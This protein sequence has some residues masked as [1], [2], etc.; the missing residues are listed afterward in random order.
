MGVRLDV[1]IDENSP[2]PISGVPFGA[3]LESGPG[4]RAKG[5]QRA[6]P[7]RGGPPVGVVHHPVIPGAG[8]VPHV[9]HPGQY[10]PVVRSFLLG[11][12]G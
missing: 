11:S 8:H 2:A 9:S 1:P 4:R 5:T 3:A 12:D 6:S 7:R 10:A